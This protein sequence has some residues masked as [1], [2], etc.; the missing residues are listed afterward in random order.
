MGGSNPSE[1]SKWTHLGTYWYPKWVLLGC[2]YT[3][4][5]YTTTPTG[6]NR[7]LYRGYYPLKVV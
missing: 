6:C 5:E 1:G 7:P 3:R 2:Y 4:R